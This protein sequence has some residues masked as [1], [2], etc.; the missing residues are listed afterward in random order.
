MPFQIGSKRLS[1]AMARVG[2]GR[3]FFLGGLVCAG[4]IGG[5]VS[6]AWASG[7]DSD[8]GQNPVVGDF[9]LGDGLEAAID[10]RDGSFH[11]TLPVAGLRVAWDSRAAADDA[12]GL[13]PR[14]GL[15]MTRIQTMGGVDV[16]T[17]AGRTF[18][19]DP[20]HASGLSG[21]GVEDLV[22]EQTTGTLPA[23]DID[24]GVGLPTP[25]GA[26]YAYIVHELGGTTTYYD[27]AGN[28]LARVTGVGEQ[29]S[30]I[31]DEL[32]PDR[33]VGVVNPDGMTTLLD[34]ESEPGAVVVRPGANLP[35]ETDPVTG[36]RG[37]MPVWRV[38]LDG[39]RL[40][41]V[42]DPNG[43]RISVAYDDDGLVTGTTSVSGAS[44]E[45]GW[46]RFDDG[47]VRAERV[48][49]VDA[50][51][52]ELSVRRW[53]T[54]GN[55]TPSSGWPA[56]GGEQDL[57]WA[58]D[59]ALRYST[60]I[61]DGATR[62]VSEYNSLHMLLGRTTIATTASGERTIETQAIEYTGTRSG[63]LP[64]PEALEG[65][66]ARPASTALTRHDAHG[67]ARTVTESYEYDPQGRTISHTGPDGTVTTTEYDTVVPAGAAL[68]NGLAVATVTSAPDGLVRKVRHTLNETRTAAIATETREGRTGDERGEEPAGEPGDA[69]DGL[70]RT[71]RVEFD[72]ADDGFVTAERVYPAGDPAA[73]PVTTRRERAVDLGAGTVTTTETVAADSPAAATTSEVTSLRHGGVLATTDPVG[74]TARV[75]YDI[76]GRVRVAVSPAGDLATTAV[77]TAQRDGRNAITTTGPDGVARTEVTDALG[78]LTQVTDNIRDGEV[79]PGHARVVESREYPHPGTT[80]TTDAWGATTT[81]RVDV[82]GRPV[83]TVTP[84]G[85]VQVAEHDDVANTLTTGLT[86]TGRLADAELVTVETRDVAGRTIGTSGTRSDGRPVPDTAT[87]YDGFGRQTRT[88]NGVLNT[89]VEH[90][91]FG[92]P[93]TTTLAPAGGAAASRAQTDAVTADRRFDGFGARLE[94]TLTG[95]GEAR[96]GGAR[97]LDAL[98]RTVGET[99]QLGRLTR[100]EYTVDGLVS[101]IVAGSGQVTE[102]SYDATTRALVEQVVTSPIGDTVRTASEHDPLTGSI[103][104]VF[105]PAD[106]PGTEIT[107][108]YDAHGNPLTVT[109]PDG[110]R[111]QYR[112]DGHGRRTGTVDVAGATTTLSHTPAGLLTRAEQRD[113]AGDAVADVS[114]EYDDFA[115]V[116]T[117]SRGNDV[118]TVY[119]YTSASLIESETSTDRDG[120][121]LAERR[122]TYDARGKL[123]ERVDTIQNP[124]EERVTTTTSHVYDA[125]D[126]LKATT[127]RN[128]DAEAPIAEQIGYELTVSGDIRAVTATSTDTEAGVERTTLR[129]FEYSPLGELT[130]QTLTTRTGAPGAPGIDETVRQLQAYDA[131]GNLT[132]ALDGTAYTYDAAN[133]PVTETTSE[134]V[135][136]QTGYWVDGT[137]KHRASTDPAS[138]VTE[139][140][141]FYWDGATLLNDTHAATGPRTDGPTATDP[142]QVGT[143][144]YLI[145]AARHARTTVD[146]NDRVTTGYFGAD[147]HSNVTEI[148][149]EHGR[150]TVRHTYSDY[151]VATI[152]PVGDRTPAAR[153]LHRN[154]F[155]FA[156]EYTD[157]SDTQHL[158]ARDY[159]PDSM[160][161]TS[162]DTAELH[163]LYAFADLN[164]ITN[165]DPSG[166]NAILDHENWLIIGLGIAGLIGAALTLAML[167]AVPIAVAATAAGAKAVTAVTAVKVGTVLTA[168]ADAIG[169]AGAASKEAGL[170]N[171]DLNLDPEFPLEEIAQWMEVGASLAGFNIV[172]GFEAALRFGRHTVTAI[173]A[174]RSLELRTTLVERELA[175]LAEDVVES[176]KAITS[177]RQLAN[178]QS[179]HGAHKPLGDAEKHLNRVSSFPA[180]ISRTRSDGVTIYPMEAYISTLLEDVLRVR[181]TRA[182][183]MG[184]VNELNVSTKVKKTIAAPFAPVQE[185]Y[186]KKHY[187]YLHAEL[188]AQQNWEEA[189]TFVPRG[190]KKTKKGADEI[191][192]GPDDLITRD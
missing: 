156:G 16:G 124:G 138:L 183:L 24:P 31:W 8:G 69:A 100:Y 34:W 122:Y 7:G 32:V 172:F 144:S 30:W 76:S 192:P 81:T 132:H 29:T 23:R 93:A 174:S 26:A 168:V 9:T 169:V 178:D 22:F 153:G 176:S 58:A 57:F 56:Y 155:G 87:A 187:P 37:E 73:T 127:V 42:V 135:T 115:R 21:Y 110:N 118:R 51:G 54:A 43:G 103:T 99:D 80:V 77:E 141:G 146:A 98:G 139:T 117:L 47:T 38:E 67:G 164:P 49:T 78:R 74:N 5:L 10:E 35:A 53:A 36:E 189:T 113:A 2:R 86:P 123:I 19:P 60:V 165:I 177:S 14:W 126:R 151:G 149:D 91:A 121:V 182:L 48:R 85:L 179:I 166:R 70:T 158:G 133:R 129:E 152:D 89:T 55:G 173:R 181:N 50:T 65:D 105:D 109:Y 41:G 154:A 12:F 64:D 148:T 171:A 136:V 147:R 94:K 119:T 46:R 44:T 40:T 63:G 180:H 106:R 25:D 79:E 134:G 61:T 125:F 160:R 75:G 97:T 186:I 68:A 162:M 107:Y 4:L 27:A 6:P 20:T 45:I 62:V 167:P 145:G 112:Y 66:W 150:P 72:V 128:G 190:G 101:R 191:P 59:P 17:P 131:A 185:T 39:G 52:H 111:V 175:S 163:N 130:G 120:L 159:D 102:R 88:E 3:G 71:A 114:Y 108:S 143:A 11:V 92:N 137:R 1:D 184:S 104:A 116:T 142:T 96:S 140:A 18:K 83:E 28:P 170:T 33:L 13:G 15:G 95:D 157:E 84:T 188:K 161:F 90:D 82:F